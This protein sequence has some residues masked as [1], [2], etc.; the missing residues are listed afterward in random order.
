MAPVH[1]HQLLK[2]D[3]NMGFLLPPAVIVLLVLIGSGFL[4][5][6][7]YA[8]H[9]AFGFGTNPNGIKP[10]SAEQMTYMAEVRVRNAMALEHEGRRA[11]G[12]DR[13]SRRTAE[14]VYD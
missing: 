12:R 6:C 3:D 11:W 4:V 9:S 5:A 1:L 13:G 8:V 14:V 2:R 10:M 7:G